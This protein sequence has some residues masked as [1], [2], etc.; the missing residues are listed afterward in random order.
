MS[1]FTQAQ[2]RVINCD[3][4]NLVVSAS[5]GSGKTSVMIERII[6][7]ILEGKAEINEILAVTFTKLAAKEMKDRIGAAII[8]GIKNGESRTLLKRQLDNLPLAS[9]ST[10][11]SFCSNLLKTYFYSA[12]VDPQFSVTDETDAGELRKKAMD[13]VFEDLYE[14]NDEDILSLLEIFVSGRSDRKLKGLIEEIYRFAVTEKSVDDF[15]DRTLYCYTPDGVKEIENRLIGL[16]IENFKAYDASFE[17]LRDKS[18]KYAP[19]NFATFFGECANRIKTA[20]KSFDGQAVFD[21]TVI[22]FPS[23]PRV[24]EADKTPVITELIAEYDSLKKAVSKLVEKASEVF[25]VQPD[26]RLQNASKAL[27]TAKSLIRVVKLFVAE[28]D[29]LKKENNC[30]DFSDVEHYALRLL[31][32][33]QIR[34]EVASGY[35]YVFVDEYQDTNGVQEAIFEKIVR[36]NGLIVGDVKQSIYSFRGCNPAIFKAKTEACANGYGTRID[37]DANFRSAL[38]VI[39]AVNNVFCGVMHE[40]NAELRY[41]DAPMTGGLLYGENYGEAKV[42]YFEK[43]KRAEEPDLG[44]YGVKKHL[45]KMKRE[46]VS[47]EEKKVS[48]IIVSEVGKSFFDVKLGA[49]RKITYGDITVLTRSNTGVGDRIVKELIARGVP[50]VSASRRSIG[51]YPEIKLLV[52]LLEF[53]INPTRD[54]PL[55]AVLKSAIGG[56]NENELSQIRAFSQDNTFFEAAVKFADSGEGEIKEKLVGFFDYFKKIRVL[57][58]FESASTVLYTVIAERGYELEILSSKLGEIKLERIYRFIGAGANLSVEEYLSKLPVLLQ[59]LTVLS[60]GGED[61]VKVMSYHA[62]KGLE[63]PVVILTE[64]TKQF[65]AVDSRGE[66]L[67]DRE[68]GIGLKWYDTSSMVSGSTPLREYVRI[69]KGY[70]LAVDEMRLLYVAMTRARYKL[71]VLCSGA[72]PRSHRA[73]NYVCANKM[74]DFLAEGDM[75]EY[76]PESSGVGEFNKRRP[77]ILTGADGELTKA[78]SRFVE[79]RYPY[80]D[81]TRLSLKRTVTEIASRLALPYEGETFVEEK[82]L[83]DGDVISAGVAYHRYLETC[84]FEKK[85]DNELIRLVNEGKLTDEQVKMMSVKHLEEILQMDVFRSLRDK[86]IYR[87]QPFI[88]NVPSS[89]TGETARGESVLVQGVI[90]LLCVENDGATIIDYKYSL[91]SDEALKVT[92]GKQLDLYAYAVNAIGG[93]K[94]K[95]KYIVNLRLKRVIE[96]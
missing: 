2:R 92:Y 77:L 21:G 33:E 30:L 44:V 11:D 89:L 5:A 70:E 50:V 66:V 90:D 46:E 36:N 29:S 93:M 42:C 53:I 6:R 41:A 31:E 7:L 28:Y 91:K 24:K 84:D 74:Q 69:K 54:I 56:L 38:N 88:L 48:D 3:D 4:G 60:S 80:E 51:E 85:A 35:K 75:E 37:L 10:I 12:G 34:E 81:A 26:V 82:P 18:E 62:S 8:E 67:I 22:K 55:V 23:R 58:R 76:C 68:Y 78:V 86:K 17:T 9:V 19:A 72:L 73:E 25:G 15:L 95:G 96:V 57:S 49:E 27:K 45:E 52:N 71:F 32:N 83:F 43:R 47:G 40:E 94:I 13:A 61:S 20:I 59:S 39:K 79:F 87:E 14:N 16:F 1:K 64:I 65:N 63:F